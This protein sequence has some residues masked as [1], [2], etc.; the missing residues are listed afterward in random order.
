MIVEARLRGE[1]YHDIGKRL[2]ISASR[3]CALAKRLE[4]AGVLPASSG[5]RTWAGYGTTGASKYGARPG[6]MREMLAD[7]PFQIFANLCA[8]A[9]D[10]KAG[11]I[12][13]YLRSVLLATPELQTK[14]PARSTLRLEVLPGGKPRTCTE[15]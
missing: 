15:G 6:S 14:L 1:T 3:V 9:A 5:P 11:S 10:N 7:L 4:R 8:M 13:E 2:G 12:A